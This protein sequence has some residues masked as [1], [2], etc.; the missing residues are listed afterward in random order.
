[1]SYIKDSL[2][3]NEKLLYRAHFP[4]FYR[5]GGWS[6]LLVSLVLGIIAY[7]NDLGWFGA[8]IPVVLGLGV[9]V[10]IMQPLW[11]TEICVTNERFMYKR[12]MWSRATHE[13]QL[14]SVEEVNVQQGLLGRLL[15][16]GRLQLRGTGIDD[17]TLPAIGDPVGLR[18]ALQD[19]IA[20]AARPAPATVVAPRVAV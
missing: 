7:A 3:Q 4:W 13:L 17:I 1:M 12:G 11:T 5:A 19:G 8:A 18:R 20:A 9:F 10:V 14:R 16:Y 6:L 2:G 15:D